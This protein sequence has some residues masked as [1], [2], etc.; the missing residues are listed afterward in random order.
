MTGEPPSLT[1]LVAPSGLKEA[2]SAPAVTR[3]IAAGAKR[4]IPTARILEVPM[5]DGGEGFTEA[6]VERTGGRLHRVRVTGPVGI[7]VA[8]SPDPRN[9][10]LTGAA[11][12]WQAAPAV[13][14]QNTCPKPGGPVP[15]ACQSDFSYAGRVPES[16]TSPM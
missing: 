8:T 7:P 12:I 9:A 13:I 10:A 15:A 1:V 4:A 16:P 2:L 5:V 3:A 6:L 14:Q 11:T